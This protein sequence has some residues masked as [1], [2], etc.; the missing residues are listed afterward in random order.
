MFLILLFYYMHFIDI[1]DCICRYLYQVILYHY[2]LII[3]P[4]FSYR[5]TEVS[6]V[7]DVSLPGRPVHRQFHVLPADLGIIYL[8]H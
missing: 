7:F 3:M 1:C 6:V 8:L 4:F 2:V 5:T